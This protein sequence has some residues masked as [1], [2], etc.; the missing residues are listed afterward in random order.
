MKLLII[1]DENKTASYLKKGLVESGFVVDVS[2]KGDEGLHLA[3]TGESMISS[4]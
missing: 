1:E 3:T 2:G 4:F